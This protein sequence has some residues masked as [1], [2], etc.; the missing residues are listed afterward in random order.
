MLLGEITSTSLEKEGFA[1]LQTLEERSQGAALAAPAALSGAEQLQAS[2]AC[3]ES[4]P[5]GGERQT[6]LGRS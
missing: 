6:A 3:A 5:V 4:V 1:K 2:S